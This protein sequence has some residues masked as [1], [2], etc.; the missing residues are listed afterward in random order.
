M[1][2]EHQPPES[3]LL[4][5]QSPLLGTLFQAVGLE[6]S[7]HKTSADKDQSFSAPLSKPLRPGQFL[8]PSKNLRPFKA[9]SLL[10]PGPLPSGPLSLTEGDK[11]I[12][13]THEGKSNA[14]LSTTLSDKALSDWEELLRL[15][16]ESSSLSDTLTNTLYKDAKGKLTSPVSPEQREAL[17]LASS[18]AIRSTMDCL[19]RAYHNVILAR[20][21][22]VLAKAKSRL[23]SSDKELL[24]ALPLDPPALFGQEVAK[25]PALQPPSEATLAVREMAKALTPKKPAPR[26]GPSGHQQSGGSNKRRFGPSP[27]GKSPQKNPRFAPFRKGSQGQKS[28][29]PPS[30]APVKGKDPQ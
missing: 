1:A 22:G 24:R 2:Q 26:S 9:S 3:E 21:D 17:L 18:S 10:G 7:G 15:A 6:V 14:A 8:P 25:T 13:P 11:V 16:L 20:R 12:L 28:Q 5:S 19:T 30:K 4:A 29:K 23:P 27:K